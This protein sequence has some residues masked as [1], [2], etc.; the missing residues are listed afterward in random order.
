[1]DLVYSPLAVA[2]NCC[3]SPFRPMFHSRIHSGLVASHEDRATDCGRISPTDAHW[4]ITYFN[5]NNSGVQSACQTVMR[6]STHLP[7]SLRLAASLVPNIFDIVVL[8]VGNRSYS[9]P[10]ISAAVAGKLTRYNLRC[11]CYV[12]PL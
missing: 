11:V 1:M 4:R 10:A 5:T 12:K 7:S 3:Q 2:T 8:E 9:R 6:C